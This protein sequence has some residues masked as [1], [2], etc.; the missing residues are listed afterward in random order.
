MLVLVGIEDDPIL[1]R[2]M[3]FALGKAGFEAYASSS[4][5]AARCLDL[6]MP[7]VFCVFDIGGFKTHKSFAIPEHLQLMSETSL[8]IFVWKSKYS[9][10]SFPAIRC[11]LVDRNTHPR[12]IVLVL[13]DMQS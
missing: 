12:D 11:R 3:A 2:R 5:M 6:A 10:N 7:S 9:T 1:S 13:N 4:E 8:A